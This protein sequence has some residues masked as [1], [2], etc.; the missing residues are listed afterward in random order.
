MRRRTT[1]FLTTLCLIAASLFV[2]SPAFAGENDYQLTTTGRCLQVDGNV[3]ETRL[4]GF[5]NG[6]CTIWHLYRVGSDTTVRGTRSTFSTRTAA[7]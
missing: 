3:P 6:V 7:S 2:P 5:I 1:G 4:Y